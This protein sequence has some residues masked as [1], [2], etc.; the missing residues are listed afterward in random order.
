MLNVCGWNAKH[1]NRCSPQKILYKVEKL[2]LIEKLLIIN[3]KS[4][5]TQCGAH[6]QGRRMHNEI[7]LISVRAIYKGHP[8]QKTLNRFSL[9][10]GSAKCMSMS[11]I[12]LLTKQQGV[13]RINMFK[14][15]LRKSIFIFV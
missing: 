1:L 15:G 12:L 14:R 11:Y 9:Q 6:C 2:S 4:F 5:V 13:I 7:P 10:V 3:E 8:S